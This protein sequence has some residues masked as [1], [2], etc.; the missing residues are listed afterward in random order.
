M[1]F[2]FKLYH[3]VIVPAIVY[4]C[5]TCIKCETDN[6]KLNRIQI[7]ALRTILKL[8]ISTPL[9]SFKKYLRLTLVFMQNSALR[10]K[11]KFGFSRVIC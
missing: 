4:S 3:T 11:F 9:Q 10:G 8:P 6:I 5:E 2:L 7:S 1:E